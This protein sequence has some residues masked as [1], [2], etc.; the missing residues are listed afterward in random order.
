MLIYPAVWTVDEAKLL[1]SGQHEPE[2]LLDLRRMPKVVGIQRSNEVGFC[3]ENAVVASV[4]HACVGLV[5]Q[6][7]AIVLLSETLDSIHRPILGPVINDKDLQVRIGLL[8]SGLESLNNSGFGI[9]SWD[10]DRNERSMLHWSEAPSMSALV[11]K[12]EALRSPDYTVYPLLQTDRQK[13]QV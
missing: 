2:L 8:A 3:L 12:L 5:D 13:R 7:N 6:S 4:S 9:V 1:S 11:L 10:H